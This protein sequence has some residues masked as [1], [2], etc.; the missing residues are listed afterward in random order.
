MSRV[1][2]SWSVT[3]ADHTGGV[4]SAASSAAAIIVDATSA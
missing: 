3:S 1:R 4:C 2:R